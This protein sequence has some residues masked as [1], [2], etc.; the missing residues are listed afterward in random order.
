M[1]E[2]PMVRALFPG[3]RP[4]NALVGLLELE[5]RTLMK[6][7]LVEAIPLP[8]RVP[9]T[10]VATAGMAF[11]LAVDPWST[12]QTMLKTTVSSIM[13][14]TTDVTTTPPPC[15]RSV[16]LVCRLV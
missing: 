1:L 14:S 16:V 12:A 8:V 13:L 9:A 11:T 4:A 5:L 3:D 7:N 6:P 2:F 15:P 10:A